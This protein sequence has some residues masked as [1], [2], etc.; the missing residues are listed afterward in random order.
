MNAEAYIKKIGEKIKKMRISKGMSQVDLAN[1]CGFEKTNMNRIEAGNTNPTIKTLLNICHHLNIK[2]FDLL[3]NNTTM[4][5][6][7]INNLKT[8]ELTKAARLKGKGKH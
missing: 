1:L 2:L 3:P 7:D 8:K 6:F 4:P 5:K